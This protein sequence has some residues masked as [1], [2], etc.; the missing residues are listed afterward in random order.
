[1]VAVAALQTVFVAQ[2]QAERFLLGDIENAALRINWRPY[3]C[4]VFHFSRQL[5]LGLLTQELG[6]A[7]AGL[8]IV[9]Q[10][11]EKILL[12]KYPPDSPLFQ[13]QPNARWT[14]GFDGSIIG[15]MDFVVVQVRKSWK[16]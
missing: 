16:R 4:W 8:R 14:R 15:V 3:S 11:I 7:F 1:M 5:L 13:S 2:L 9:R 6:R 10:P 12:R